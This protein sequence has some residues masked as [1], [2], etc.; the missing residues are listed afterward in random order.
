VA[1]LIGH[2]LVDACMYVCMY[3][4]LGVTYTHQQGR[5]Q[6]KQHITTELI[7]HTDEP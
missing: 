1:A 7:T 5:Y 2:V 4:A 3:G 6:Y